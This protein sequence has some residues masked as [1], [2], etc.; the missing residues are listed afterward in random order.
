MSDTINVA[1]TVA[2]AT[3]TRRWWG[4][5]AL[6]L[7]G[8]VVGLDLTVLNVALPTL[9][10]DL[11]ASTGDL[12]WFANAYNLVLAAALLPAGLLGDRYGRKRMLLG[13]LA[14]FGVASLACAYAPSV[15]A[16][17][18][19]RALLGLGAA[20]LIPMAM[21]MLSVLFTA[22]ERLRA[23]TIW[24]TANAIGIPLG[25]IVGGLL[26]DTY[27]WGS[28]F[29]INVPVVLAASV[30]VAVLLPESRSSRR[31]RLDVPGVVASSAGLVALTYGVVEAGE[32]SWGDPHAVVPIVV[33]VAAL[34]V[35]VAWQ[36]RLD[37]R[38]DG[39][40][41]VDLALFRSASFTWGTILATMVTFAMFGL[42]FTMPQFF[43]AVN[44]V[45]ALGTGLRLLPIIAGMLVGARTAGRLAPQ[46]GAKAM[47][48]AGFALLAA[49]LI[50]G[51]TTKVETGY[52]FAA[53][54]FAVVGLGLGFA[55]PSAMDAALGVLPAERSGVGSAVIQA[56]RQVGGAIGVAVLGTVLN[57]AYRSGVDV[58]GL[59]APAAEAVRKS[60]SGGVAVA[61]QLGSAPLVA[62]V[63]ESFAHAMDVMLWVCGGIAVVGIVL[64]LAFLPRRSDGATGLVPER[65]ESPQE[66]VA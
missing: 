43:Q 8:L 4:L 17:I 63:Q 61:Q 5:A 7:S 65:A 23:L 26:L 10:R 32:K 66:V 49:G 11:H 21:S 31:P 9:A 16:L 18:G 59:P 19:A 1:A 2:S 55:M 60:V 29:L 47:V 62:S 64:A 33:G 27:W 28:V 53:T 14:M 37:R 20:F 35:F 25:P 40:P 46:A 41:L 50:L 48:A 58:S 57:A 22:E 51:A 15:G 30:A 52:G 39:Q 56:V 36:R 12:Q 42:M 54:W 13:A 38:P 34:A 6:A 24:I 3:D 45:N 44:G